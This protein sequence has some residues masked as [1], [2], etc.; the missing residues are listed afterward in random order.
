MKRF[1]QICSLL[2]LVVVFSAVSANAQ[3][4]QRYEAEIPFDFNIGSKSYEAGTYTMKLSNAF[5]VKVMTL[6]NDQNRIL[7]NFYVLDRGDSAKTSFLRFNRSDD[8]LS[9]AKVFT[10]EKSF[11]VVGADSKSKA[12]KKAGGASITNSETV[13]VRLK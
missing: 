6:I 9:L 11:S 3:T 8:G 13:S 1:I 10:P 12:S 2:T 5:G 4:V 7:Q